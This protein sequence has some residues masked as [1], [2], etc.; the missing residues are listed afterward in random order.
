[1]A[2]EQLIC[3]NCNT[4]SY[5]TVFHEGSI[6]IEII[7]WLA[8][9]IPGLVYSA[10]RHTSGRKI[11]CPACHQETLIPIHSPRGEQIAA[12]IY[13]QMQQKKGQ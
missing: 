12:E 13:G 1:M 3:T 2:E 6:F 9:L 8:F 7:L 11:I 10:W 4:P 5:G